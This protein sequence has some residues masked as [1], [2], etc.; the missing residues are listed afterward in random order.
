LGGNRASTGIGHGSPIG[1]LECVRIHVAGNQECS[2]SVPS[3]PAQR[4]KYRNLHLRRL[5]ILES[6]MADDLV[7]DFTIDFDRRGQRL[8]VL[9]LE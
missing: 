1:V 5:S 2:L 8:V 7:F 6:R 4:T 9:D 3:Y